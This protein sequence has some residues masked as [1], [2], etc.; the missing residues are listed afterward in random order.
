MTAER[1]GLRL[2]QGQAPCATLSKPRESPL[3]K[4]KQHLLDSASYMYMYIIYVFTYA[5]Y[6]T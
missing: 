5:I 3:I 2:L 6:M 4:Y 1:G